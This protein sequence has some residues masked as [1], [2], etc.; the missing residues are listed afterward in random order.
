VLV[1]AVKPQQMKDA[2]APLAGKL[3][4]Q[5]VV[6]IAAGL[7]MA[8]ISRW[9]GGYHKAVVRTMPNTPALI[10]AGVTGLCADPSVDR[11]GRANAEKVLRAVGSTIWVDDEAQM[12]AVTAVSGS[13]PGLCLLLPRSHGSRRLKLGFDAA[14]A[15]QLASKPL[16]ARRG[17]PSKAASR[18]PPCAAASPPRAAPPKRR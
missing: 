11:E 3:G 12:D 14:T 15:R 10:G 13:G 6:S 2:V 1:L 4:G 16:S 5:L 17:W 7:R 9:L 8:D 18:W